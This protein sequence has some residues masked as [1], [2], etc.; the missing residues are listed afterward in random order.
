MCMAFVESNHFICFLK[1][2]LLPKTQQM[3][4]MFLLDA[5]F[6]QK[7]KTE[8]LFCNFMFW[9]ASKDVKLSYHNNVTLYLMSLFH[10]VRFY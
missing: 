2:F 4:F 3:G 10:L 8:Y 9:K 6:Y 1:V 5:W 7:V